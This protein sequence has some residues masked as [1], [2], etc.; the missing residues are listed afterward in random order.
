MS[1]NTKFQ[2]YDS[3]KFYDIILL[4]AGENTQDYPR[5]AK[6]LEIY[7]KGRTG[8]IFITGGYGGF[9]TQSLGITGGKISLERVMNE[10]IPERDIFLDDRSLDTL[11]N[12]AFPAATPL[13][14]NPDLKS[15]ASI[16]VITEEH[17]MPRSLAY[18]K[19]VV[20]KNKLSFA[21]ATGPYRVAW[22][23]IVYNAA[24]LNAL[25]YIREPNPEQALAF[26]KEEHPFYQQDWFDKPVRKRK[27]ELAKK[28]IEWLVKG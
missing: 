4:L 23:T 22:N 8:G 5:S 21:C 24:M 17:H 6:A 2:P 10:R 1:I 14:G 19:K 16:L 13:S 12:F 26:L 9:A 20:P 25:R 7:S 18:A 27:A 28:C 11:G 15:L 3:S